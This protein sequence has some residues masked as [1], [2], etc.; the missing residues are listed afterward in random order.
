ME[1]T[2]APMTPNSGP[3][4]AS[5]AQQ[6]HN[7]SPLAHKATSASP[8]SAI[9]TCQ[10]ATPVSIRDLKN[11]MATAGT[12]AV[13]SPFAS[14]PTTNATSRQPAWHSEQAVRTFQTSKGP[15]ARLCVLPPPPSAP[16]PA[17]PGVDGQRGSGS[18]APFS[19]MLD[20][21]SS[22][23]DP[24]LSPT[25][26]PSALHNPEVLPS[27]AT[28]SA[29]PRGFL[30]T[31]SSSASEHRHSRIYPSTLQVVE[32]P[33]SR[34]PA[35]LR[36][37]FDPKRRPKAHLQHRTP[38]QSI[39]QGQPRN[40]GTPSSAALCTPLARSPTRLGAA[41]VGAGLLKTWPSD[42]DADVKLTPAP[43][44][45]TLGRQK[46]G[47]TI[48]Q[49]GRQ[50]SLRRKLSAGQ[51]QFAAKVLRRPFNPPQ[52]AST[53]SSLAASF[54]SLPIC[55]RPLPPTPRDDEGANEAETEMP[56]PPLVY[57]RSSESLS[58]SS[59][60]STLSKASHQARRTKGLLIA[61]GIGSEKR[62]EEVKVS[63]V[64]DACAFPVEALDEDELYED[65][66]STPVVTEQMEREL[67]G[68]SHEL[69]GDY[70]CHFK[71]GAR[72]PIS[73]TRSTE[74]RSLK[75][76]LLVSG[77][78]KA[79]ASRSSSHSRGWRPTHAGTGC[80]S[81]ASLGSIGIRYNKP[82]EA[83]PLT[84]RERR[85]SRY[86]FSASQAGLPFRS[87]NNSLADVTTVALRDTPRTE[88]RES[89]RLSSSESLYSTAQCE[90]GS[91]AS[92]SKHAFE[93][94]DSEEDSAGETL[95]SP[96]AA[97]LLATLS[98]P[99][100]TTGAQLASCA[101]KPSNEIMM[102]R[103]S[104]RS[105]WRGPMDCIAAHQSEVEVEDEGPIMFDV[106][107]SPIMRRADS[108]RGVSQ[109]E[110]AEWT[111][112]RPLDSLG[113]DLSQSLDETDR[114][115]REA[116]VQG[117]RVRF[118]SRALTSSTKRRLFEGYRTHKKAAPSNVSS[119]QTEE[120]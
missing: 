15:P 96:S 43:S 62:E 48:T 26:P 83:T 68:V 120:D 50:P 64:K 103:A 59:L 29:S 10:P 30:A 58:T 69:Q 1:M 28:G 92:H 80:S 75:P 8:S 27:T 52:V 35:P 86:A 114:A 87:A 14:P 45:M 73:G 67:N 12:R 44:R 34:V 32:A 79:S 23:V 118:N 49:T 91:T 76:L 78:S 5:W 107:T 57:S 2:N 110:S 13:D 3:K 40:F 60:E 95:G 109:L 99:L 21:P 90:D 119:V 88:L 6:G 55:D 9:S 63:K 97:P 42:D 81:S 101:A 82:Q 115:Q 4:T 66:K 54:R 102:G 33:R 71:F 17:I 70:V 61:L 36:L 39:S 111:Q 106:S 19:D 25:Q 117:Q 74:S 94:E 104:C 46:V 116:Q 7:T 31:A 105:S 72:A 24:W 108:L 93:L 51:H 56:L 41:T 37:A 113:L 53:H 38:V 85:M 112:Q 84:I 65:L 11:A 77:V 16:L 22:P 100:S 89:R 18:P 98:S 20:R 47:P